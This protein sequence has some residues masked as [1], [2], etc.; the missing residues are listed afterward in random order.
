MWPEIYGSCNID[1]NFWAG[2]TVPQ[3]TSENHI[4][5]YIPWNLA[6]AMAAESMASSLIV[7]YRPGKG[8]CCVLQWEPI[9]G[10][11][12]IHPTKMEGWLWFMMVCYGLPLYF[13]VDHGGPSVQA[14]T[15]FHHS[16]ED[17]P[18]WPTKHCG[19]LVMDDVCRRV[20]RRNLDA[21]LEE[22]KRSDGP[23]GCFCLGI[24]WNIISTY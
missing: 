8:G 12:Y 15:M 18:D 23:A 19:Y 1:I 5:G 16:N 6:L 17:G 22:P 11:T 3:K 24:S 21:I 20:S 13:T 7:P 9:D 14:C 2:G 4:F 10:F